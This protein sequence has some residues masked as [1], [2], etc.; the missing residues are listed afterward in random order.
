[1]GLPG[2]TP[3]PL[4]KPPRFFQKFYLGFLDETQLGWDPNRRS[5]CGLGA[6]SLL[7]AALCPAA[8]LGVAVFGGFG[9]S[10][11]GKVVLA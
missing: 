6:L 4:V 3:E 9:S 1:M 10:C 8:F 7:V 2:S 11:I 5:F